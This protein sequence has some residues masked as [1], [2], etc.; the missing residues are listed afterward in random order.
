VHS[1]RR[2]RSILFWKSLPVSDR[3]T[4]LA[5]AS[6]PFIILPLLTFVITLVLQLMILPLSSSVLLASGL[7]VSESMDRLIYRGTP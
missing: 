5:K 7:S 3:T 2:D 6:I 4:V 1:E